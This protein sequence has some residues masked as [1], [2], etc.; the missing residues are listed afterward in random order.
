MDDY[1]PIGQVA[2]DCEVTTVQLRDWVKQS[3]IQ[4]D[5]RPNGR[6]FSTT[7]YDRIR[8]IRDILDEARKAGTKKTYDD[9]R[10][11][12]FGESLV[13]RAEEADQQKRIEQ[14]MQHA[15]TM[16]LTIT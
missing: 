7:E 3:L 14:M 9:V 6:Y 10:R 5:H 12:L 16:S 2:Q 4:C 1:R 15:L 13:Q 8:K 11:E